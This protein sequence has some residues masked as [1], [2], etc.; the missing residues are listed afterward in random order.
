MRE[1]PRGGAEEGGA[2]TRA[3]PAKLTELPGICRWTRDLCARAGIE[4]AAAL[5]LELC[6]HELVANLVLHGGATARFAPV[7][8]SLAFDGG[9]AR[10]RIE[11]SGRPFDPLLE[12]ERPVPA[13]FEELTLGGYGIPIVRRLARDLRHRREGDRNILEFTVGPSSAGQAD[14]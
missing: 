3:F 1:D 5:D 12:P 13:S 6:V 4:E 11:D 14:R 8:V 7:R 10:V 9:S 2:R